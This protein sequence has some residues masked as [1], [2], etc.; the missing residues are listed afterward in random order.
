M[1]KGKQL[2]EYSCKSNSHRIREDGKLE[3]NWEGTATGFG[4]IIS[5]MTVATGEVG[6]YQSIGVAYLD[7]GTIT[8]PSRGEGE[9]KS[10]GK[11]K[12]ATTGMLK[13]EMGGREFIIVEEG[14]VELVAA[15]WHWSGKFYEATS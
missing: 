4:V 2:G 11:H 8:S 6:Q 7:D 13:G 3:I 14:T 12:W 15:T 10:I 9:Y 5:T 1:T